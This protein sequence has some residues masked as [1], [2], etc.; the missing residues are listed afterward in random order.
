MI[1]HW[2]SIRRRASR[3]ADC[4][5]EIFCESDQK[6]QK[7]KSYEQ[8]REKLKSVLSSEDFKEQ[9]INCE[10]RKCFWTS[11]TENT[12]TWGEKPDFFDTRTSLKSDPKRTF[13]TRTHH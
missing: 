1:L 2:F 11:S 10:E 13:A 9:H 12:K 8:L 6:I 7:L 5:F 4:S 3:M